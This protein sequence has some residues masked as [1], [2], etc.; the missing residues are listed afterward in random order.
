MFVSA[1]FS[2]QVFKILN[3]INFQTF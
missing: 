3:L 2:N 1:G